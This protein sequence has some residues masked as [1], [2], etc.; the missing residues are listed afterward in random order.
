V[1]IS[2]SSVGRIDHAA[3]HLIEQGLIDAPFGS[4]TS[5]EAFKQIA[6]HISANPLKVVEGFEMRGGVKVT[7]VV[8]MV[9]DKFVAIQVAAQDIGKRIKVGDPVTAFELTEK[10]RKALGLQ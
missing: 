6:S 3:R 5:R 1:N 4:T 9:K 10:Q 7:T 2:L 8:G